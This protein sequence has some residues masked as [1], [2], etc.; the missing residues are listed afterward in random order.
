[1]CSANAADW[2]KLTEMLLG[3]VPDDFI[4]VPKHKANS[5]AW[6][7]CFVNLL[8]VWVAQFFQKLNFRNRTRQKMR[9]STLDLMPK[10][11]RA[12]NF[13]KPLNANPRRTEFGAF[14][15]MDGVF[16]HDGNSS[17]RRAHSNEFA[18]IYINRRVYGPDHARSLRVW[19]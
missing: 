17:H 8:K 7:N 15:M 9:L 12:R 13:R 10:M 3:P 11:A 14:G 4:F 16:R 6:L 18:P 1:M 19:L 2:I 5:Y